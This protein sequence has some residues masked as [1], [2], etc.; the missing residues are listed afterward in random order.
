M[1]L[2][3]P[4]RNPKAVFL[5][6]IKMQLTLSSNKDGLVSLTDLYR[7]A[8]DAGMAEGKRDPRRW[9]GEEGEQFIAFIVENLHVR[10]TDIYKTSKARADRGG[11]T[12][13][14]WQIALA[15]AKYLSPELHAHVNETY[16]RVQA[17]DQHAGMAKFP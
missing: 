10:R 13:A 17:D 6:K 12:F 8:V 7:Q 11:G 2:N 15:Y 5:W 14:H 16:A 1:Q 9:S 4:T 3:E